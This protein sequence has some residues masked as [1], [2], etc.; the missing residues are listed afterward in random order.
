MKSIDIKSASAA[1]LVAFFNA[2]SEKPVKR[3][4]DRATAEKRVAALMAAA[5]VEKSYGEE[6][7]GFKCCP[8]CNIDL[9]NGIGQ[10]GDEVNGKKIKHEKFMFAC[11]G[12]GHEFGTAIPGAHVPD[13]AR[14]AGVAKSWAD[15][16]VRAAR[17]ARHA[18]TVNGVAYGSVMKAFIALG[19]PKSKL[20][21]FRGELKKAGE[22]VFEGY[23]FKLVAA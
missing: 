7:S 9:H 18:V 19:L 11:L 3:F 2:H 10:H 5:P 16:S 14:S 22:G 20:I 6:V 23:D 1:E 4:A 21:R 17:S 8:A 13:A 12:C 15:A